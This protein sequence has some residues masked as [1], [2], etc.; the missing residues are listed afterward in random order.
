[1]INIKIYKLNAF[2]TAEMAV[3]KFLNR[4]IDKHTNPIVCALLLLMAMQSIYAIST[5][6]PTHDEMVYVSRGYSVLKTND[7]RLD[8]GH[9]PLINIISAL[10]LLM[11]NPRLPTDHYSWNQQGQNDYVAFGHQFYY[12]YNKPEKIIFL[13][14][15]MIL[16]MALILGICVFRWA[17]ELF[18]KKAGLVAILLFSFSPEIISHS[19][20]ATTDMGFCLF[21]FLSVYYFWRFA[22]KQTLT[23]FILAAVFFSL[24]QLSKYSAVFL[25]PIYCLIIVFVAFCSKKTVKFWKIRVLNHKWTTLASLSIYYALILIVCWLSI[26]MMYGFEGTFAPIGESFKKDKFHLEYKDPSAFLIKG[27]G[28][29]KS[30]A[31]TFL[32]KIPSPLPYPYVRGLGGIFV[33]SKTNSATFVAGKY[34]TNGFWYYYIF[35]LAVKTPIPLLILT[36]I[37]FILL[38]RKKDLF[39]HYFLLLPVIIFIMAISFSNLQIGIRHLLQIYPM[40]FVFAGELATKRIKLLRWVLGILLSWYVIGTLIIAPHYLSYFNEFVGSENGYRYLVDTNLEYGQNLK[41]LSTYLKKN[42]IRQIP[43]SYYGSVDAAYYG[44]NYTYMPSAIPHYLKITKN[45]S[46]AKRNGKIAVSVFTLQGL[47]IDN[48]SC[49]SWLRDKKPIEKIG[50]T[51]FVYD[52][53]Q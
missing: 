29:V 42:N 26:N 37:S 45:G 13:S 24:A 23:G 18:G 31:E 19:S 36:I 47:G 8:I 43:L 34:S 50:Y 41:L 4:F 15:L 14:R 44:I 2:I 9:P 20:I 49:Y 3:M 17:K 21:S 35:A 46:C 32:N 39:D 10:P 12:V 33:V 6:S 11:I 40:L 53:K 5:W 25:I 27:D 38:I 48:R 28:W 52:V 16:L 51:L 22:K 1:M 30:A 7:F